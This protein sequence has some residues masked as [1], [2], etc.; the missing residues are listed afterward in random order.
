MD[1]AVLFYKREATKRVGFTAS[2]RV[3]N[4]VERNFA[5]RRLRALFIDSQ[6]YLIDGVYI[7][8]AKREILDINFSKLKRDIYRAYKRVG[9]VKDVKSSIS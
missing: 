7:F 3:G 6:E 1:F 2:K 4:A 8:V 5:K 9:A